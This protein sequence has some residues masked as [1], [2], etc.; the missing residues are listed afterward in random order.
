MTVRI[1]EEFANSSD[2]L[3]N[4]GCAYLDKGDYENAK[5]LLIKANSIKTSPQTQLLLAM[6][7]LLPIIKRRGVKFSITSAEKAVLKS[8]YDTLSN[9]HLVS[10]FQS[11]PI[12]NQ[13]YYW[14]KRLVALLFVDEQKALE[15]FNNL[16]TDLKNDI[17]MQILYADILLFNNDSITAQNI[18]EK[19]YEKI[20]VPEILSKLLSVYSENNERGKIE[21]FFDKLESNDF[22]SEG[23]VASLFL[24]YLEKEIGLDAAISKI[25]SLLQNNKTPIFLLYTLGKLY[26]EKNRKEEGVACFKKLVESNMVENYPPRALFAETLIRYDLLD[27]AIV[28][29]KP[30]SGYN[31]KARLRLAQIMVN[32]ENPIYINDIAQ[33]LD[34]NASDLS[35]HLEWKRLKVD[36]FYKVDKKDDALIELEKL[37]ELDKTPI[38]AFNVVVLKTELGKRGGFIKYAKVLETDFENPTY[39]MVAAS[40][41]SYD[42][43]YEIAK[44]LS[45]KALFQNADRLDKMLFEQFLHINLLRSKNNPEEEKAELEKITIG[46]AVHLTSSDNSFWIV[47]EDDLS[48]FDNSDTLNF[49]GAIHFKSDDLKIL[50]ILGERLH[51]NIVFQGINYFISEVLTKKTHAIRYCLDVYK[52]NYPDSPFMQVVQFD[53]QNPL[54]ALIPDLSKHDIHKKEMLDDYNLKNGVGVP[55]WMITNAFGGHL[56][57]CISFLL[58][59]PNQP[60]YAGEIIIKKDSNIKFVLSATTIV[61]L[62]ITDSLK[63]LVRL[64]ESVVLPQLVLDYFVNE[65]KTIAGFDPRVKMTFDMDDG[66]PIIR[67]ITEGG[68]KKRKEFFNSI[69]IALSNH[70]VFRPTSIDTTSEEL[71]IAKK[72]LSPEDFE[73]LLLSKEQSAL[74]V[75][76]DLFSRRLVTQILGNQSSTNS[77]ALL[78]EIYDNDID[79]FLD[80]MLLLST[81]DFIYVYNSL[82]IRVIL[83]YMKNKSSLIS[84]NTCAGKFE[85][86]IQN[87]LKIKLLFDTN[88]P[89]LL[90]ALNY[91][92][93][94]GIDIY[95][96]YLIKMIIKCLWMHYSIHYPGGILFDHKMK[97]ISRDEERSA[98]FQKLLTELKT[99]NYF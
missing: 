95:S 5:E 21:R 65:L 77:I 76:D 1:K 83:D 70:T 80:K 38:N 48:L 9:K 93:D 84:N 4:L 98:Y 59:K 47:I 42:G 13:V 52:C 28:F 46:S 71:S 36:F 78:L 90:G 88:E 34:E 37:Y 81:G 19:V 85:K 56:L 50:N 57:D 87:S 66:L 91:L 22:D 14:H 32:T 7:E 29:L 15:E 33:L 30:F 96:E 51:E 17:D 10:Y 67:K 41:Y 64:N 60:F 3:H 54:A 63:D 82:L 18:I 12:T 68:I 35:K 39:T 62:A 61:L 27:L 79:S 89:I 53:P 69:V 74:L 44:Q 92:Y 58:G 24:E 8:V 75:L 16:S 20:K 11:D 94:C 23:N 31:E 55:L 86:V 72:V 99:G 43:N 26:C 6:V 45:Y 2:A 49:I 97:A 40:C 73:C 25:S